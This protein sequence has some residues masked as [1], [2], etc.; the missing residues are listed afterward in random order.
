M[1]PAAA[2]AALCLALAPAGPVAA[3]EAERAALTE[4]YAYVR[5]AT[6]CHRRPSRPFADAVDAR[7]R[8]LEAASGLDDAART[9][10]MLLATPRGGR[11]LRPADCA[12]LAGV[13]RAARA[14]VDAP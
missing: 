2:L 14:R 11:L 12:A 10:A 13:E 4:L 7:I 3:G 8:A 5:L 6:Y 9:R 1:R